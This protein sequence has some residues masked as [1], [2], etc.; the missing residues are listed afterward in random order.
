MSRLCAC[1]MFCLNSR[2][3]SPR[4]GAEYNV[5]LHFKGA[6]R[7]SIWYVQFEGLNITQANLNPL[8]LYPQADTAS[9]SL[10]RWSGAF[11]PSPSIVGPSV[12]LIRGAVY[13]LYTPPSIVGRGRCLLPPSLYRWSGALS[14]TPSPSTPSPSTPSPSTP[15]PS[16]V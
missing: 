7:Q 12:A 5:V 13:S 8:I 4:L 2:S 1:H 9:L 16:I 15:S 10:Y 11:T 3:H 6:Q 14:S